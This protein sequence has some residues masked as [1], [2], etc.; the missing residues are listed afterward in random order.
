MILIYGLT[1]LMS[2]FHVFTDMPYKFGIYKDLVH[3][4][5]LLYF[6]FLVLQDVGRA[7]LE[8]YSRVLESLAYK[9]ISRIED[10]LH[11]D[12]LASNGRRSSFRESA[13]K[14]SQFLNAREELERLSEGGPVS[15]SLSDFMGWNFDQSTTDQKKDLQDDIGKDGRPGTKKRFLDKLER[16]GLRS[17]RPRD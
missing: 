7:V 14:S 16:S 17:P 12:N 3:R 6:F 5:F 13:I 9:V 8:S 15:M 2:N 10:V 1:F 4:F 11:A